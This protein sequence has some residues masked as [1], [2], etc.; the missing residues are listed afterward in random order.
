MQV[1]AIE[2]RKPLAI[3]NDYHDLYVCTLFTSYTKFSG[4]NKLERHVEWFHSDFKQTEKE[5]K[6]KRDHENGRWDRKRIKWE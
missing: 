5:S 2:Y 4:Y 1:D 6:R 3:E